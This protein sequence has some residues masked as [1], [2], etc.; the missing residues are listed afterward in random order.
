MNGKSISDR[1]VHLSEW[2]RHHK[3]TGETGLPMTCTIFRP[4]LQCC[5]ILALL[6]FASALSAQTCT[7]ANEM[8]ANTKASIEAAAKLLNDFRIKGFLCAE[9]SVEERRQFGDLNADMNHQRVAN[10]LDDH[11]RSGK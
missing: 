7:T 11:G 5:L 6:I 8:D 2:Y 4:P 9:H 10:I 1:G 3:M